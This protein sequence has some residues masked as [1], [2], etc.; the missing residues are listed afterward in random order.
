MRTLIL[1]TLALTGPVVSLDSTTAPLLAGAHVGTYAQARRAFGP[2]DRIARVD[3]D[4]AATW[5]RAGMTIRFVSAAA[6]RCPPS[7]LRGWVQVTIRSA[8]WRTSRG[9]RVGAPLSSLH[10]LYPDAARLPGTALWRLETGGPL[11][12]GGAPLA[13]AARPVAGR[14]GALLVLHVPACG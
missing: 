4:C 7:G 8:R 14:V 10:A 5:T 1:C 2:P 11:C 12:D 3:A 6:G 13:L 9:L